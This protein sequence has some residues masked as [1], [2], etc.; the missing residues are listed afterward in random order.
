M[1]FDEKDSMLFDDEEKKST[2]LTFIIVALLLCIIAGLVVFVIKH[3]GVSFN[4]T[5][6]TSTSS[7]Y[8]F[9]PTLGDV[10]V[11]L[12]G[13]VFLVVSLLVACRKM[14]LDDNDSSIYW[15]KIIICMMVGFT[16]MILGSSIIRVFVTLLTD[17]YH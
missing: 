3:S 1:N 7:C 6:P 17:I 8:M 11:R 15:Y 13:M 2:G 12:V 5:M 4:F 14:V 10:M 9:I 16:F